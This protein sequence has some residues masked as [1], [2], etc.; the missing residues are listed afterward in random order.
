MNRKAFATGLIVF[1]LVALVAIAGAGVGFMTNWFGLGKEEAKATAT[2]TARETAKVTN[3]GKVATF[4][5]NVYDNQDSPTRYAGVGYCWDRN[6]VTQKV[7]SGGSTT[8]SATAGTAIKPVVTG[9]KV[10]CVAFDG[11]QYGIEKDKDIVT[12]SEELNLD[13]LNSSGTIA[14]YYTEFYESGSIETGTPTLII[15]AGAE[16]QWNKVIFYSNTSDKGFNLKEVCISSN[17]TSSTEIQSVSL[18]GAD[19]IDSQPYRYRNTHLQCMV[20][21]QA[22]YVEDFGNYEFGALRVKTTASSLVDELLNVTMIDE[23][24]Y[25]GINQDIK[26]GVQSD[27]TTP[28]NTGAADLQFQIKIDAPN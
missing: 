11:G 2:E 3:E 1:L 14:H 16:K 25:F 8:L 5:L 13:S 10:R 22:T 12:E 9:D 23:S 24:H 15:A 20:L 27:T 19:S 4:L 6:D 17:Q 28:A 21:P 7:I 18:V 26:I